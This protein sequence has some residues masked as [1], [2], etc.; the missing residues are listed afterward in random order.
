MKKKYVVNFFCFLL[1]FAF[2]F[3]DIVPL[4]GHVDL[5]AFAESFRTEL[6]GAALSEDEILSEQVEGVIRPEDLDEGLSTY[7]LD[8]I[9][10]RR[11]TV[12]QPVMEILA[13]DIPRPKVDVMPDEYQMLNLKT[14]EAFN[15]NVTLNF[16]TDPILKAGNKDHPMYPMRGLDRSPKD[17]NGNVSKQLYFSTYKKYMLLRQAY[18]F[19]THAQEIIDAGKLMKHPAADYIYGQIPDDAKA[20][21]MH[22]VTDPIYRSPMTTGLY[23]APGEVVT[24]KIKGLKQGEVLSL[25]THHQDTMGY[26]GY[27]KDGK[28]FG[29]MEQ[30]LNYWDNII[31]EE[32]KKSNP[33]FEQ[34]SYGIHGQWLWQNQKVP[35]MGTT[36]NFVGT[37]N[38]EL[39]EVKIGSMYGGPLYVKPTSSAVDLEITGAVLT[40]HFVLGVTTVEEFE[41]QL[42]DA[43]GAIATLDVENGQLIGPADA[44][45]N[46]DD[47]E[48]L[49]YFWH[50]V[51]AIDISLNGRDYNYNMTMCYD[52]HVP[53]GEAVALNSNFCAQPEYWFPICMNYERL[54]T[55]GNWGTFH[56]LG[57]VQAKTHGVN[58]GFCDGDGEVW[59]NTLILLI[60]SMLCNMD[61]RL[62]GVEHGE[63]V[64]PFTAIER[65]Q[66]ITQYYTDKE[67]NKQVKI[68]DYGMINEGGGAHFDQLSMYATLL[69]SFGPE[70][71]VD[72]FYTYKIDPAYCENK[73]ADFVYRIGVVDRVNIRD[74][75][76]SNYFANITDAMFT[77][78][79]LKFLNNLP[80]F[81]P[82]AYRWANGIDGNET[83]RKYDVD[84]THSTLFDLSEGNFATA[85]G[86]TVEVLAVTSA[87]SDRIEYRKDE[88]KV[89]Y[90]PP[91]DP[92][93]YD[94]FD[95]LVK[96]SSGRRV[97]LNVNMRLVYKGMYGE[98]W[99][100]GQAKQ[101][102]KPSVEATKKMI[103]ENGAVRSYDYNITPSSA[104]WYFNNRVNDDNN[105][106]EYVHLQFK[107]R[108]PKAGVYTFYVKSDDC[109]E[110]RFYK[111]GLDGQSLGSVKLGSYTA[112]FPTANNFSAT[113]VAN[114][115]VFVDC[116]LVN[117][118]GQGGVTIGVH[119][120]DAPE[121]EIVTLPAEDMLSAGVSA[122]DLEKIKDFKGWQPRF[123]DSIKNATI[124][125]QTSNSGWEVLVAPTAQGDQKVNEGYLVD[126]KEDT[127]FHSKYQNGREAPPHVFIIDT[128]EDQ[129]F[130]YFEV[131]RRT[132]GNDRLYKYA[133]YSCTSDQYDLLPHDA[134]TA[135]WT[136]LFDGASV[137]VNAARQRIS[138]P[139][140]EIRYFKFIVKDNGSVNG[141]KDGN[142]V[143]KE[144]YA[145]IESKLSQTVKPSTYMEE[146]AREALRQN[147]DVAKG[148]VE[149]SANGKLTTTKSNAK[150]EFSFLGSG[151]EVFADVA[152]DFGKAKIKVDDG[153]EEEISLVKETPVFNTLVYHVDD[154]ETQV[155]K[156][157]IITTEERSFNIS[158]INVKYGTPVAVD[159]YPATEKDGKPDYGDITVARQFTREWKT[160]V[161]DYKSLTSIKFVKDET[162]PQGYKDTYVRIDTYIRLYRLD[163]ENE[164][165]IA[166]VYPG[167]IL[168]PIEC[169]SLF[170]GCE[171]LSEIVFDNFDT[172]F[173]RG[174][175]SMF[176]G[177]KALVSVDVSNFKTDNV[178]SCGKM[179]GGCTNLAS[180]NLANF[181]LD[182]NSNLYRM[183][184]NCDS[185]ASITLPNL[186]A[187]STVRSARAAS[188]EIVCELPYVYKDEDANDFVTDIILGQRAGHRLTLHKNHNLGEVHPLKPATC[189]EDGVLAYKVCD[190][191][192]CK[193]NYD[194]GIDLYRDEDIVLPALGHNYGYH[195]PDELS[196]YPTCTRPG[197]GGTY[198]C[199]RCHDIQESVNT[200]SALGHMYYLDTQ[201]EGTDGKGYKIE[202]RKIEIDDTIFDDEEV[203]DRVV[204]ENEA[205]Y[206]MTIT[207]Y[208][209]CQGY[210]DWGTKWDMSEAIHCGDRRA[211]SLTF[212]S[213]AHTKAS[214]TEAESYFFDFVI[215]EEMLQ[216]AIVDN[217]DDG[218]F[219]EIYHTVEN[220]NPIR[221]DVNKVYEVAPKLEHVYKEV[222]AVPATCEGYGT[223]A[224]RICGLCNASEGFEPINPRGHKMQDTPYLAPTCTTPGHTAGQVCEY[225][226]LEGAGVTHIEPLGHDFDPAH[227]ATYIEAEAPYCNK[228]GHTEGWKCA[229]CD[230]VHG[231]EFLPVIDHLQEVV[232]GKAPTETESGLTD[233]IVCPR[234][235][236]TLQQ[237]E[238]IPPLGSPDPTPA[239]GKTAI[240][241][242][243]CGVGGAL[244]LAIVILVVIM[245]KKKRKS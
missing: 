32:A 140:M 227:G 124:D 69:H 177:C 201:A 62:V 120:P 241:G 10:G 229:R 164:H 31:L 112:N 154:L 130:N 142:T 236:E 172:E 2:C 127:A 48:K 103:S 71:F 39:Q 84:G 170:S 59:N 192:H 43:P 102:G 203:D 216:Q 204:D 231:C 176:Y 46:C 153:E 55:Q 165:K 37:G 210:S 86:E 156:V 115:L 96:T 16:A 151:F 66:R 25:Y 4:I 57:H 205:D 116:D 72:M 195:F 111:N 61:T 1:I 75:V 133:L 234:C 222:A 8:D 119:L 207:F 128:K 166:F 158:F 21:T 56:E 90:T 199:N 131:L 65:S 150:F 171:A 26:Q 123:V 121:G 237:Q 157:T 193:F 36:F 136:E 18:Y 135:G 99:R 9:R 191:C 149:N 217:D 104:N 198:E 78:E 93:E 88:Q 63:Y 238:V 211:V 168:A 23:L 67:T 107:Y 54:T 74:W 239:F 91:A 233:G 81:V 221:V 35:C 13:N 106:V 185:L 155:H 87:H 209:V 45:R 223:E 160:Y 225:C 215:T 212:A 180:L 19:N 197:Q 7:S 224:G 70:K 163:S 51:F 27:D 188:A 214:C 220:P 118:G 184:E 105:P 68:T 41:Q 38:G 47:I 139:R 108:V 113:L 53:A 182:D 73:R 146:A 92:I 109:S 76:N 29:N 129:V 235:G 3:G 6:N 42:R 228:T 64:H 143:I 79:Q 28:G 82:V 15:P 145:G 137:N 98:V 194:N 152:P 122:S 174:A 58:W 132:N 183:F 242:T 169:G 125:D 161:K 159:E 89:I 40:P 34:Y 206:E 114:D 244:I 52:L 12:R 218:V 126:G 138:F 190:V 147:D 144:V 100:L 134:Q 44:M 219:D 14:G 49:A 101:L 148:F 162:A 208:F 189:L 187:S 196:A 186:S 141:T 173:M 117:W 213:D 200:T 179:F 33:D 83:A 175:T 50:S 95:I 202:I 30:Y 226:G 11:V 232:P 77:A 97:T 85:P 5:T 24:V 230:A 20:V 178:L 181:K 17:E 243:A 245:K 240:I 110:T 94:S 80:K 60:Y 22:M 167:T